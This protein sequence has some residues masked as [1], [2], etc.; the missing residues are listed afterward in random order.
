VPAFA[1][2]RLAT[3]THA[4]APDEITRPRHQPGRRAGRQVT[5]VE[6][7]ALTR[8]GTQRLVGPAVAACVPHRRA[9]AL[10]TTPR[11]H[12][13]NGQANHQPSPHTA[14]TETI[15]AEAAEI[16]VAEW[17]R[18]VSVLRYFVSILWLLLGGVSLWAS[19][20]APR[21]RP[22]MYSPR[23]DWSVA[24]R[25]LAWA[26]WGVAALLGP[27]RV[28]VFWLGFATLLASLVVAGRAPWQR[29]GDPDAW[30]GKN[31]QE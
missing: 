13:D 30:R 3:S 18:T 8:Y 23:Q 21:H 24:L 25:G 11:R 14:T 29:L 15:I 4:D 26:L 5:G 20:A 19:V 9:P 10:A 6:V 2:T 31:A 17:R 28:P 16:I 7:F 1:P 12:E 22:L 27:A